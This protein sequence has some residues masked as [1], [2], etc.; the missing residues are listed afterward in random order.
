MQK[1]NLIC[2]VS[3]QSYQLLTEKKKKPSRVHIAENSPPALKP[4]VH[5]K[6]QFPKTETPPS[7]HDT[8]EASSLTTSFPLSITTKPCISPRYESE[9]YEVSCPFSLSYLLRLT[10]LRGFPRP[11]IFEY[12]NFNDHCRSCINQLNRNIKLRWGSKFRS[13]TCRTSDI[14]KF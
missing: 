4:Y 10:G 1:K 13:T 11:G 9:S 7:E 3:L 2:P 12:E 14:S 8:G 6:L 5:I